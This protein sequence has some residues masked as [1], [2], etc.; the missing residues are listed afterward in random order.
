MNEMEFVLETL[1]CQLRQT[2][3][4]ENAVSGYSNVNLKK[5]VKS[6]LVQALRLCTGRT[7]LISTTQ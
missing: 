1:N 5:G 3:R 4:V 7:T 6:T 2:S